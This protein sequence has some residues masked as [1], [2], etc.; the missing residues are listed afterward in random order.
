M[1]V[2]LSLAREKEIKR[3]VVFWLMALTKEQI[4][5]AFHL[6]DVDDT[7]KITS[8]ELFLLLKG[9]GFADMTHAEL[10]AMV[11][12]MDSDGSG[13]IEYGEFERT[14]LRKRAE[15]GSPEEIWR[16]FKLMDQDTKGR[17]SLEDLVEAAKVDPSITIEDLQRVLRTC[18]DP[19]RGI[20]YDE[21]RVLMNNLQ[22]TTRKLTKV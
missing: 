12:A 5:S 11:N 20:S 14:V 16:V 10:A 4:R 6:F 19:D 7:G 13:E 18:Q 1:L 3:E 8:A 21:W 2:M 15:P 17:L 9:I 22:S